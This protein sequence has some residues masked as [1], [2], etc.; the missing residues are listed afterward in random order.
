MDI[1]AEMRKIVL[2]L[3]RYI[4]PGKTKNALRRLCSLSPVFYGGRALVTCAE[5]LSK[6][7][8]PPWRQADK[9][10]VNQ[11]WTDF[12]PLF[13][14]SPENFERIISPYYCEARWF[15]GSIYNSWFASVDAELYYSMIRHFRPKTIVEIGA[16]HSTR[17]ALNAVKC[18]QTGRIVSVDP[19]P[20]TR[21]PKE[22][23]HMQERVQDLDINIF[24]ELRQND[25]LFLDSSHTTEEARYHC[26]HILP[27]LR[28]GVII[29]HHDFSF[30]YRAYLFND[31]DKYGEPDVLLRFYSEN[32]QSY[33]VIVCASWVR[34]VAPALIKRLVKSYKWNPQRI[35]VSLWVRKTKTVS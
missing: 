4:L 7:Y 31:P 28:P 2:G 20:R 18:N 26:E 9:V 30:P 23:I 34:Y 32:G 21:L 35:P 22:V 10:S 13:K 24:R 11:H 14:A 16:G 5:R 27:C 3:N 17:F 29:H 6:T 8:H 12:K 1:Y 15:Y 19:C 33:E 25:I